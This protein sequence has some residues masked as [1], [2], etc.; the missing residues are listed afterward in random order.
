MILLV[1]LGNPGSEYAQTRHNIGFM[2]VDNLV[3]RYQ[4]PDFKSKFKGE[5]SQGKIGT[6]QVLFLK[7]HTYMNL[8][9]ESIQAVCSFYKIPVNQVIVIHDDLDLP[10]GKIKVKR[11]GSAGGHNGL[12]SVD[13]HLGN[14]YMRIRVGISKPAIKEQVVDWVL[15]KFST[16]DK[17]I[18]DESFDFISEHISYL[19]QNDIEG[20]MNKLSIMGKGK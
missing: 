19:F 17:N 18:L 8:S 15:S 5:I 2:A 20:F 10:V 1:G 16:Q 7:P 11:G 12:K 4:F 14:N 3:R 13:A 9:G 6:E